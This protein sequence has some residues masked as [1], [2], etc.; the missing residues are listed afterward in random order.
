LDLVYPNICVVCLRIHK[1][2]RTN[3]CIFSK[4]GIQPTEFGKWVQNFPYTNNNYLDAMRSH[5]FYN[6]VLQNLI[7]SLKYNDHANF[8]ND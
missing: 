2:S 4:D 5:W 6:D 1:D 8:S 3:I 7:H